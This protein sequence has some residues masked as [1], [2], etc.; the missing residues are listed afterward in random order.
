[1]LNHY[2]SRLNNGF[3]SGVS[4]GELVLLH[5]KNK[6]NPS[7]T[8]ETTRNT[9]VIVSVEELVK[10]DSFP[11]IVVGTCEILE[12]YEYVDVDITQDFNDISQPELVNFC[13][14]LC[15]RNEAL[16][17]QLQKLKEM[18]ARKS[19]YTGEL[20]KRLINFKETKLI[21]SATEQANNALIAEV[22]KS[23]YL[24]FYSI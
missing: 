22:K 7:A 4:M 2:T 1:M 18:D 9:F 17:Q 15:K 24:T 16:T 14:Q 8:Q 5:D 10:L 20:N 19:T 23:Y 6:L 13:N 11:K 3:Q 21:L 12:V